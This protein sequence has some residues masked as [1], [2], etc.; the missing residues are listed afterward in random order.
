MEIIPAFGYSLYQMFLLFCV[1]SFIGWCIEVC[2]MTYETG[3]YQNRGFLNM[4]ICPIYGFGVLMLV[5]FFRPIK[6]NVV[7]LFF[8]CAILCTA[9]ELAVG[10]GMEKLFHNVWWDYSHKK[11]NFKG[12]ICAGVTLFWGV[13]GAFVVRVVEPAIERAVN[14]LP[15]KAGLCIIVVMSVLIAVDLVIS[16]MAVLKLNKKVQRID[17][18]SRLMLSVSVKT[19]KKLASGTIKVMAVKDSAASKLQDINSANLDKLRDEYERLLSERDDATDRLI[20]AFPRIH[21]R[22]YPESLDKLKLKIYGK[23]LEISD[24]KDAEKDA[25]KND[26]DVTGEASVK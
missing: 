26:E 12:Y 5:I 10:I 15:V 6:D 14:T 21:S 4:P 24:G 20:K 1:W 22:I 7:L 18:L 11:L 2:D 23:V 17:E 19:G 3:E 13:G 16:V 9:F 25:P 8:A